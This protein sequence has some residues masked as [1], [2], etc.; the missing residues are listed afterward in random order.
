MIA[1]LFIPLI[2]W[3]LL[4]CTFSFISNKRFAFCM[5]F[6]MIFAAMVLFVSQFVCKS[7]IPGMIALIVCA[8]AAIP[9]FFI[10][11]KTLD[12]RTGL[13]LG[14]AF[15]IV[16]Y[17]MY[18]V[19]DLNHHFQIFDEWYHW[20]TMVKECLRLDSFYSIDAS[21]LWIHKD[22]PPFM[23]LLEYIWC[24]LCG[25]YSETRVLMAIHIFTIMLVLGP[26][27][28]KMLIYI[29]GEGGGAWT[30]L[31]KIIGSI[32]LV[33]LTLLIIMAFDPYGGRISTTI[34]VDI[35][36]PAIF[37]MIIVLIFM[38]RNEKLDIY[39]VIYIIGLQMALILT[40][41][42]GIALIMVADLFM[43]LTAIT[44]NRAGVRKIPAVIKYAVT[45]VVPLIPYLI[46]NRYIH[47]FQIKAQFAMSNISI[48]DYLNAFRETG[49]RHDTLKNFA[50]ALFTEDI[51]T[52]SWLPITYAS[53]FLIVIA[54]IVVM[55]LFFKDRFTRKDALIMGISFTVGT[56]GYAFL[57]SVMYLFGFNAEE[58]KVLASYSRYMAS[59][60][61]GEIL[62]LFVV[63]IICLDSGEHKAEA[64]VS[65]F[66]KFMLVVLACAVG[67]NASNMYY[68]LPQAIRGNGAAKYE[69]DA[70]HVRELTEEG[71]RIFVVYNNGNV[72]PSWWGAYQP[73]LQ[74]YLND[75]TISHEQVALYGEKYSEDL[76][77][78]VWQVIQDND[79]VYI[80]D[81]NPE[82]DKL[83]DAVGG[84]QVEAGGVYRIENN[85]LTK[86]N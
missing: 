20:G 10:K 15:F 80:R 34:I 78:T 1:T 18:F 16:V 52:V 83:F 8:V 11:R 81:T 77:E 30:K 25:G 65:T 37:A 32:A 13:L 72:D 28:E 22:Y 76:A 36:V 57:M 6:S 24:W 56:A 41:Q 55:H 64:R 59:Y 38:Q 29:S 44:K 86:V 66:T 21:N 67:I 2:F 54:L 75:R 69:E 46:W 43:I 82:M 40:K 47:T 33:I 31:K 71:S 62:V 14:M 70:N 58:M 68:L 3:I 50:Q 23:C 7:F 4:N 9:L 5:P 48:A 35:V 49:L 26:V 73:Y 61:L 79:Y 85:T 51:G 45:V 63:A 84:I 39:S 60:V 42:I 17:V 19:M 27:A 53:A 74:Y 12:I